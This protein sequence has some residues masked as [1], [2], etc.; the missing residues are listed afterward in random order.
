MLGSA[1]TDRMKSIVFPAIGT[2]NLGFPSDKVAA[3][4]YDE[5]TEFSKNNGSTSLKKITVCLYDKDT[6]N[7]K[8]QGM[9]FT[10]FRLF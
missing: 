9:S 5:F 4:M 6:E 1:D 8:V 7:I 2:G 10:F 3:I